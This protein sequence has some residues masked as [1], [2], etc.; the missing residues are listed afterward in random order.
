MV[1]RG[2][3]RCIGVHCTLNEPARLDEITDRAGPFFGKHGRSL[4]RDSMRA[5]DGAVLCESTLVAGVTINHSI[6]K[7][8]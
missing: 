4:Q 8:Q 6:A 3:P 1:G 7:A 2:L 5:E